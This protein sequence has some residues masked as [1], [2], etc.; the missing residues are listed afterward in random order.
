MKMQSPQQAAQQ[1]QQQ[2]Q[3]QLPMPPFTETA[4]PQHP[5][6]GQ[7]ICNPL[8][9]MVKRSKI[10]DNSFFL[11]AINVVEAFPALAVPGSHSFLLTV[12]LNPLVATEKV[13]SITLQTEYQ[14]I[15]LQL[16]A[17]P[18]AGDLACTLSDFKSFDPYHNKKNLINLINTQNAASAIASASASNCYNCLYPVFDSI[19][20]CTSHFSEAVP[21]VSILVVTSG[22]LPGGSVVTQ[23]LINTVPPKKPPLDVAIL[24]LNIFSN[25]M[26]GGDS[27]VWKPLPD[28]DGHTYV[29]LQGQFMK[30]LLTFQNHLEKYMKLLNV[31]L[32]C[33]NLLQGANVVRA[34]SCL[35]VFRDLWL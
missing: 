8:D 19:L 9:L 32:D 11:G 25:H 1:Q 4:A 21:L 15:E 16:E 30:L 13:I 2:Q 31:V 27:R 18:D 29:T 23:A 33:N 34:H 5:A 22:K 26:G 14:T 7:C 6:I 24:E 35:L 10:Q 20:R 3:Q 12:Q 17:E 28:N